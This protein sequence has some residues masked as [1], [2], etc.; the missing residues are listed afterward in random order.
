MVQGIFTAINQAI[1]TAQEIQAKQKAGAP[2][3]TAMENGEYNDIRTSVMANDSFG[4]GSVTQIFDDNGK[5]IGT[6]RTNADGET[7]TTM[8]D[9][10]TG[11]KVSRVVKNGDTMIM[12]IDYDP[13]TGA[14][15]RE[16]DY[17]NGVLA[18]TTFVDPA[19]GEPVEQCNY[20]NGVLVDKVTTDLET[21]A[22]TK[23]AF[24]PQGYPTNSM[25]R[26]KDN[27]LTAG[28]S[29]YPG[30]GQ[31]QRVISYAPSQD[32]ENPIPVPVNEKMYYPSGVL[33]SERDEAS[34][35]AKK[36]DE[37]GNLIEETDFKGDGDAKYVHSK[38]DPATGNLT[39]QQRDT[40]A[41]T[42]IT[43][44]DPATGVP[45]EKSIT[46]GAGN[47]ISDTYFHSNGN[48]AEE[49]TIN[50]ET[51]AVNVKSYDDDGNLLGDKDYASLADYDAAMV[52]AKMGPK[53][54][55]DFT[56]SD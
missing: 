14:K 16:D 4:S 29:F 53:I 46:D 26:D 41:G 40:V 1:K 21:G 7:D 45:R 31:P 37:S 2:V 32:P 36:Y 54:K 47:K 50:P 13:A 25:T 56:F 51:G 42:E 11:G 18:T 24:D 22:S 49:F 17:K 48:P 39:W 6:T 55:N 38:F 5:K 23:T 15:T 28:T 52:D 12:S 3:E 10:T 9:P 33:A 43:T 20:E 8:L 27:N 19:S 35:T 34:G 44:F 30:T